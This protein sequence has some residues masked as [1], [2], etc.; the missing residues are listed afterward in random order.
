[1]IST[2]SNLNKKYSSQT[3]Q[4]KDSKGGLLAFF[5]KLSP[6]LAGEL[7]DNIEIVYDTVLEHHDSQTLGMND[8][9][10]AIHF[11]IYNRYS[12]KV[13]FRVLRIYQIILT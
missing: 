10:Y 8:F 13:S 3:L 6:S 1:M 4:I 2:F 9:Y 7:M 5:A 11:D 12:K